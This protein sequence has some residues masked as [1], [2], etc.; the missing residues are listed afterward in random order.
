MAGDFFYKS[1][2]SAQ[3]SLENIVSHLLVQ[4]ASSL[5]Y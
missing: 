3:A 1:S 5:L 4:M 2:S